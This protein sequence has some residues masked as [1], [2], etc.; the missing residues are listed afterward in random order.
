MANKVQPV[1][2]GYH[3]I[4]PY[5]TV[6]DTRKAVAFY[7]KALGAARLFLMEGPDGRIV[8]A[9]MKIGDSIVML[10]EE[11]GGGNCRSPQSLGG[12]SVHFMVYTDDV[13]ALFHRAVSAGAAGLRQPENMFWGDRFGSVKDPFGHV[14]DLATHVEDVAP[15]EMQ[16]RQQAFFEKMKVAGKA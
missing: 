14:W 11:M 1:P 9:E 10:S 15:D 3:T 6:S 7:E 16:R 4:T 5:L 2:R 12:T 13:D 8:H